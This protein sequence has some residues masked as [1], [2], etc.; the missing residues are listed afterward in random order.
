M[1]PIKTNGNAIRATNLEIMSQEQ[2]VRLVHDS[3]GISNTPLQHTAATFSELGG[4]G[5]VIGGQ[6]RCGGMGLAAVELQ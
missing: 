3:R 6:N 1:M 4:G 2:L 5:G